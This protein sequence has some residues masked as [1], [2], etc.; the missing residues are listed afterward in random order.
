MERLVELDQTMNFAF[1]H[2]N[3][4]YKNKVLLKLYTLEGVCCG[5]ILHVFKLSPVIY[6]P[7]FPSPLS[8]SVR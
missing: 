4:N 2:M 3:V 7:L 5:L 6:Y 8:C 1:D